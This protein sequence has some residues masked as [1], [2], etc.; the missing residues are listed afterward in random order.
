[1]NLVQLICCALLTKGQ[2]YLT[3]SQRQLQAQD[4]NHILNIAIQ[5]VASTGSN[6][7]ICHTL[8]KNTILGNTER[9]I[10]PE[11]LKRRLRRWQDRTNK[12]IKIESKE[13]TQK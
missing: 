10:Q 13:A 7:C 1:M 8:P 5:E 2:Q 4:P 6:I 12:N 9:N 11:P 3:T